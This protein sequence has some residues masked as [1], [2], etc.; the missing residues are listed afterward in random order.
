M[1][2]LVRQSHRAELVVKEA[3]SLNGQLSEA[4]KAQRTNGHPRSAK[5]RLADKSL[6]PRTKKTSKT[7][8]GLRLHA[9]VKVPRLTGR[10]G[11]SRTQ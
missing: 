9:P 6:T 5:R 10:S 1:A 7:N 4:V 2:K 3:M 11:S 8:Q